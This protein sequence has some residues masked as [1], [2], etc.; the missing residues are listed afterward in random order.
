MRRRY[1]VDSWFF[2]A[3]ID[4]SMSMVVMQERKIQHVL[5]NDHHFRQEG[6]NVLSDAP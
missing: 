3:R 5:T 6:F 4:P 1:F 2:I